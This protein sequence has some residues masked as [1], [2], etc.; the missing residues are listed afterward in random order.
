M[1]E[2]LI[3][4]QMAKLEGIEL[5]TGLLFDGTD[6]RGA[7]ARQGGDLVNVPD[8]LSDHN[9]VQRVIDGLEGDVYQEFSRTLIHMRG[10]KFVLKATPREKCEALLSSAGKWEDT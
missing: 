7:V 6:L 2:E 5:P 4:E 8:Y 9:A 10:N 1:K 3:I